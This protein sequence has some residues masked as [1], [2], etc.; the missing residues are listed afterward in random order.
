MAN[1]TLT[2]LTA[3][4]QMNN[5]KFKKGLT[6]SQKAMKGFSKQMTQIG[7]TI[8][9]AFSIG[10]ITSFTKEAVLLASKMEGVKTAFYA[11]GKPGLLDNL[12]KA[13]RNTVT[14]LQLMQK[15]VQAKNFKIPLDQLA[16][17]FEFATNRAIQ[18]GESVDYLVE[19]II[20]GIGRKSVLVMDNL[21]ISAAEL[22]EEVKKVGDFGKAAGNIIERSL[23]EAGDVADTLA[24]RIAQITTAWEN[25]KTSVGNSDFIVWFL[26]GVNAALENMSEILNR[27]A[28]A[29]L[30]EYQEFAKGLSDKEPAEQQRLLTEEIERQKKALDGLAKK[31]R[32]QI[33]LTES[34]RRVVRKFAETEI[35]KL[36]EIQTP[37]IEILRFFEGQLDALG[38]INEGLDDEKKSQDEILKAWEKENDARRD[39]IGLQQELTEAIRESLQAQIGEIVGG[40]KKS[41]GAAPSWSFGGG[42]TF[43][44]GEGHD[45][46][47][48][49][50]ENARRKFE[51]M[52][53]RMEY[54]KEDMNKALEDFTVT[55]LTSIA[56][57]VGEG[58]ATNNFE[59]TFADILEMFGKFMVQM[60]GLIMSY[61][62]AMDAFQNAFGN[63]Y[64][65]IAAG[66]ALAAI[67]G[68]IVGAATNMR[69][70][71]AN[72]PGGGGGHSGGRAYSGYAY[73]KTGGGG[74]V[75]FRISGNDL[76]GVLK[77]NNDKTGR[78]T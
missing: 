69:S 36:D 17:Y 74:E 42:E 1:R 54:L 19:S 41:K 13:T 45:A 67:G 31:R 76:V 37:L 38:K 6:G 15:A 40:D 64:A 77:N 21:G 22:Q 48:E 66:I 27:G 23:R 70:I 61:G 34:D 72:S 49:K 16:T 26:R 53:E 62:V 29:G 52:K 47:L 68:A 5:S 28:G 46:L 32:E 75:D 2:T 63:P 59:N 60:G 33:K 43:E 51:D 7:G 30:S 39:A 12:R 55:A 57:W 25:F 10:A 44:G 56:S 14:D 71:S 11:L 58:L 8:A 65:A 18:T 35:K 73:N 4:L 20:T 50:V 9:A 24:T 3:V 78:F